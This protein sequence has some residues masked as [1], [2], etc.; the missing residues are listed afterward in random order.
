M[1]MRLLIH[2]CLHQRL[3][4]LLPLA[5][6]H[7]YTRPF[8]LL[9]KSCQISSTIL[10]KAV[11]NKLCSEADMLWTHL[12]AAKSRLQLHCCTTHRTYDASPVLSCVLLSLLQKLLD[13]WYPLWTWRFDVGSGMISLHLSLYVQ[14]ENSSVSS[15]CFD[16]LQLAQSMH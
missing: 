5:A 15:S 7:A 1:Y 2:R 16:S 6:F 3:S 11:A 4:D 13:A 10:S 9:S 12:C 14:Q 8:Q